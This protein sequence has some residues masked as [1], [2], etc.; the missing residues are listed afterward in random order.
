MLADLSIP[1][2]VVHRWAKILGAIT[3]TLFYRLI[4]NV[5]FKFRSTQKLDETQ[6]VFIL[7]RP[8]LIFIFTQSFIP[9]ETIAINGTFELK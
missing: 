1:K 7:A 5:N 4:V 9:A 6:T 8:F 3:S 2:N